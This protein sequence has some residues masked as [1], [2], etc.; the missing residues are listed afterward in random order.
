MTVNTK[1]NSI[2]G[3]NTYLDKEYECLNTKSERWYPLMYYNENIVSYEY[4]YNINVISGKYL[5]EDHQINLI[6]NK[7]NMPLSYSYI[8][9][10]R[11]LKLVFVTKPMGRNL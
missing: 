1:I 6:V 9:L 4:E 2:S 8:F 5:N 11:F 10:T 3:F 7:T